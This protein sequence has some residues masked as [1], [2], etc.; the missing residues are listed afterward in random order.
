[1]RFRNS[2]YNYTTRVILSVIK[3]ITGFIA[4]PPLIKWLGG[5]YI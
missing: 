2:L 5:F 4:T 1:M 3:L